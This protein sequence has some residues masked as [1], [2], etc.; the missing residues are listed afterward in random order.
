MPLRAS[1]ESQGHRFPIPLSRVVAPEHP[2]IQPAGKVD[3]RQFEEAFGSLYRPDQGAPGKP[4]R[5]MVALHYRR[6]T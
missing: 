2:L 1:D 4:M 3:R 5:L 6:H